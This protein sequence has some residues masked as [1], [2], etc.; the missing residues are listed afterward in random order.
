M[1]VACGQWSETLT[2]SNQLT[3][4]TEQTVRVPLNGTTDMESVTITVAHKDQSSI[5]GVYTIA[6]EKL[7]PANTTFVTIPADTVIF[8]TEPGT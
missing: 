7:P 4:N 3:P 1:I 8:L 6:I 5:A 2:Y